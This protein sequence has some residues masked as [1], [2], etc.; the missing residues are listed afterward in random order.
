MATLLFSGRHVVDTCFLNQVLLDV[1]LRLVA[2][3]HTPLTNL[4]VVQRLSYLARV[5]SR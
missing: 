5:S 3:G 1:L 4:R 2:V